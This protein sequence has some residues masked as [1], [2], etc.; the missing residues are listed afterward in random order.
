MSP[1]AI[2][3]YGRFKFSFGSRGEAGEPIHVH[4]HS[5]DGEIMK[6]W[7]T[8]DSVVVAKKDDKVRVKLVAELL[9]YIQ[10]NRA[11]VLVKW[12]QHF[13][14]IEFYGEDTRIKTWDFIK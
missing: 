11:T 4:V 14:N 2:E 7:L 10:C 1:K 6:V 5:P 8:R 3:Q 13:G 12:A 9:D